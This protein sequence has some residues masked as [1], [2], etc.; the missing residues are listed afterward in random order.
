MSMRAGQ[1]KPFTSTCDSWKHRTLDGLLWIKFVNKC[2]NINPTM[3]CFKQLTSRSHN[4]MDVLSNN[5]SVNPWTTWMDGQ[6]I[7]HL[8]ARMNQ[9][10][11]HYYTSTLK[12]NGRA[13][14]CNTR[15]LVPSSDRQD[16]TTIMIPEYWEYIRY[17]I[18][19]GEVTSPFTRR[20]IDQLIIQK[21]QG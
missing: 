12:C 20:V 21:V 13:P 1:W 5:S 6:A 11:M 15:Y 2:A 10:I 19:H 18:M 7:K 8:L 17:H 4:A 3:V 16:L 14:K 9:N